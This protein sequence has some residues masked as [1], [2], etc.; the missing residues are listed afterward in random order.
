MTL[1]SVLALLE[2]AEGPSRKLDLR[3]QY[4]VYDTRDFDAVFAGHDEHIREVLAISQ[5]PEYTRSLDAAL[6]L[7][8]KAN[9]NELAPR[10]SVWDN[11]KLGAHA[12][13][14]APSSRVMSDVKCWGEGHLG[15][16]NCHSIKRAISLLPLALC[17]AS[18]KA[19][20]ARAE[21]EE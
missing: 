9:G 16:P 14:F 2:K 13:L 7:R 15:W 8:C 12:W 4:A 21:R 18:I 3:I 19:R 17:I 10:I 5:V 6:T 11:G 1:T 20:I